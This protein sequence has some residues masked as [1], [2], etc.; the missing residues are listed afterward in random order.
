MR[1]S[2]F[3]RTRWGGYRASFDVR[4]LEGKLYI[5]FDLFLSAQLSCTFK[6][7]ISPITS[8]IKLRVEPH[9]SI[10]ENVKGILATFSA[11]VGYVYTHR[12]DWVR[13]KCPPYPAM[14][15][16]E[17]QKCKLL[18]A[19]M[20][21]GW[22]CRGPWV[23]LALSNW[24]YNLLKTTITIYITQ[25]SYIYIYI[26]MQSSPIQWNPSLFAWAESS[27]NEGKLD[28]KATRM[29]MYRNISAENGSTY[30]FI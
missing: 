25:W 27:S 18:Q 24:V 15:R 9:S 29:T 13:P 3:C 23:A 12:V 30:I 1:K 4:N 26:H 7:K 20:M 11:Q 21:D 14:T 22:C 2:P 16:K 6:M 8:I 17:F 10:W 19:T 5:S 28:E